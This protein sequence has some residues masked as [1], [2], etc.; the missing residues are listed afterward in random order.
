M[1]IEALIEQIENT[2]WLSQAEH[3]LE[4]FQLQIEWDWL[5]S[6]R[7][8][9]DPFEGTYLAKSDE[10]LYD[11]EAEKMVYKAALRSLQ[12]VGK[13]HPKL[14]DG[15]HNYTESMKGSA[16]FACKHAAKEVLS[17]Q[18]GKWIA[19]L[20]LYNNGVWPCGIT[21]TGELVIL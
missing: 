3:I 20:A 6:S 4:I 16:L 13:I 21:Q 19:I 2:N 14:V 12:S 15:P 5:P 7:D 18:P 11:K 10:Q 1:N 17:N 9:P 8:Q